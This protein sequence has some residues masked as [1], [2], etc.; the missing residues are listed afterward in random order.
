M[1]KRLDARPLPP[2]EVI[3]AILDTCGFPAVIELIRKLAQPGAYCLALA[4]SIAAGTAPDSEG[5]ARNWALRAVRCGLPPGSLSRVI[6]LGLDVA[7]V[8]TQPIEEARERLLNLTREIQTSPVRFGTGTLDEWMD[9]CTVATRND[10][11]GLTS[12]EALL[13]GPGWYT[14]W[15][16]FAMVVVVAE[17]E[18]QACQSRL[19]LAAVRILT[20]VRDPF[21]G[22]P[23]ACDLYSIHGLIEETIRRAVSLLD[24]QDW[25]EAIEILG[26]VC[27]A[28]STTI[29]RDRLLHLVVETAT[30]TRLHVAQRVIDEEIKN[31]GGGRYYS[32]LADYQLVA[33]RLA[34]KL[35][36][37]ANARG[38]W[39]EACRLLVAYGWRKDITIYELLNPLPTLIAVN[40]ARGRAAVARVQPLCKRVLQ[41][42]DGKG[43]H[44]ARSQRWQLLAT[45]DPCALSRLIQPRLLSSCNDPNWLLHGA[46]SDLW[47]A[48][49][50]RADPIVAG[51]LRL[52]LKEPLDKND[53][54]AFN[55]LA[56]ICDGTG[57]DRPSRL[58]V[59]LLA[60]IDERPFKY[61]VSNSNEL[62]DRDHNRVDEL[63]SI[64]ARAHVPRIAP[65]PTFPIKSEDLT[66]SNHDPRSQPATYLPD[67]VAVMFP[68]GTVGVAQATNC[69]TV[70]IIA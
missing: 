36:N 18:S 52:T 29:R 21:L 48:W 10:R 54:N 44:H 64:A 15:L 62:L 27:D 41:H 4:E 6:A 31:G 12:A 17:R 57:N 70:I 43:T 20:E 61:S 2:S 32:D 51:A 25:E 40:P 30:S 67:Q 68:P 3:E 50:D 42:T 45:A 55:L 39:M 26:G 9:A 46:R 24:D 22:D 56:G 19:G 65:L 53:R 28:I 5:D 47:R 49:H 33:A 1:A 7:E 11:D 58:M 8:N 34:L 66:T 16:R 63:N 59:S 35:G 13:K 60:R 14:C 69:W 23:R 37:L 38:H